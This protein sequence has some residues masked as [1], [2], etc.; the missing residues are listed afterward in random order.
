MSENQLGKLLGFRLVRMH[1]N[2]DQSVL[3]MCD[4][5][6]NNIFKIETD[7]DCCSETWFA[8][9]IGVDYLLGHHITGVELLSFS[10]EIEDGRTRQEV[11][12]QYGFRLKTLLG[13]CDFIY[14]NSSNGYYGGDIEGVT[15]VD[16]IPDNMEIIKEDWTS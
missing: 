4:N 7:A 15:L 6:E 9:I 1:V 8:D 2:E 3:Y 12:I 11:D 16:K 13:D 10:G 5:F 14:R